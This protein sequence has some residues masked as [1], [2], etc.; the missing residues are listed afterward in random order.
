MLV[1][2]QGVSQFQMVALLSRE[3]ARWASV[4][5][6]EYQATTG[7]IAATQ[8]DVY[9]NAILPRAVG[10]PPG[11]LTY[12]VSWSPNNKPGGTVAVTV[13]YLWTPQVYLGTT[14]MSSTSVMTVSY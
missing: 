9:T 6:T 4:H 1:L 3:G 5:G 2:G 14:T 12:S 7:R 13:N 8:A 10:F 11:S